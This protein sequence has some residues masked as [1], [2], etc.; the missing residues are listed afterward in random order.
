MMLRGAPPWWVRQCAV[1][2]LL[3]VVLAQTLGLVHRSLYH[4]LQ[5][6]LHGVGAQH[7]HNH[8]NDTH[9]H[10]NDAHSDC[11]PSWL[12]GLFAGHSDDAGC[13]LVDAQSSFGFVFY[14]ASLALTSFVAMELIAF[15]Q[16]TSTA[17][18][19]ALFE[20]RGPPVSL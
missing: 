16:I 7:S 15:S 6:S 19:A 8:A 11:S 5:H 18:A 10:D 2:L 17:R 13:R 9:A 1:A 20:A 4:P 12:A 3:A 14:A